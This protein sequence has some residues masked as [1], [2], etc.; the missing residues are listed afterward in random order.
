MPFQ[1]IVLCFQI[2]DDGLLMPI[3]P[4]SKYA[5]KQMWEHAK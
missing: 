4:T 2:I 5:K 3:E 1:D